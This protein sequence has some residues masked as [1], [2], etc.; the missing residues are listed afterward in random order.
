MLELSELAP[1]VHI[2]SE[3]VQP[4]L[5]NQATEREVALAVDDIMF[6]AQEFGIVL[7]APT[8]GGVIESVVPLKPVPSHRQTRPEAQCAV[9]LAAGAAA[10]DA[11]NDMLNMTTKPAVM[12]FLLNTFILFLPYRLLNDGLFMCIV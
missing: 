12:V 11:P 7:Q 5:L 6:L 9:A 3:S 2:G 1:C 8:A 4:S 10:N